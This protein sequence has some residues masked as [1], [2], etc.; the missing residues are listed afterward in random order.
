MKRTFQPSRIKR[1]RTHGFR[2]RMKTKGGRAVLSA[3]RA[4]GRKRIAV[5]D[6]VQ[7]GVTRGCRPDD[8]SEAADGAR[9]VA[10]RPTDRLLDRKR[11]QRVLR[12]GRRRSSSGARR[13]DDGDTTDHAAQE[14]P[15]HNAPDAPDAPGNEPTGD[16]RRPQGG[17]VRQA[18]SFQTAGSRMVP[19]APRGV[20]VPRRHRRHRAASGGRSELGGAGGPAVATARPGSGSSPRQESGFHRPMNM[21]ALTARGPIEP[22]GAQP[23]S[24]SSARPP[25]WVAD[26]VPGLSRGVSGRFS[27]PAVVSS[28]PA[29]GSREAAIARHGLMRGSLLGA[30]RLVR[31]HPF[32][33]GG[34]DPVP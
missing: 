12:R 34:F 9:R 14:S 23:Q 6:L 26:A 29:P 16:H 11:F 18:E 2:E 22:S 33:A 28:P 19:P 24:D 27:A 25:A 7:V 31:C 30:R 5:S 21:F 4:K 3:R 32:H 10:S 17:A 13:R 8:R 1:L 20:R 15:G